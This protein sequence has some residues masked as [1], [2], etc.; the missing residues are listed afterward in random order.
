MEMCCEFLCAGHHEDNSNGT[1]STSIQSISSGIEADRVPPRLSSLLAPLE[2]TI[3]PLQ[4]G[5]L[6]D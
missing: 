1:L 3:Q 6:H 4:T 5:Q 2:D